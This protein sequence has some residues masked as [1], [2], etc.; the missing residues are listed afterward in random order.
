MISRTVTNAA[1]VSLALTDVG[2]TQTV[3]AAGSM[4]FA[5]L[6]I[7]R[8][9]QPN[10][11]LKVDSQDWERTL[12]RPYHARSGA[13]AESM[14][15]IGD[16]V[17]GGAGFVVRVMPSGA[18]MPVITVTTTLNHG[19]TANTVTTSGIDYSTIPTLVENDILAFYMIDGDNERS[20]AIKVEAADVAAYGA[21]MF[22]VTLTE[23]QDD[24]SVTVLDTQVV[25]L[26]VMAVD[27]NGNSAFIDDVLESNS[28][29]LRSVTDIATTSAFTAVESS[30]FV[31]G[32]SGDN[33]AIVTENY[34]S[35]LD[36]LIAENKDF[37]A[38]IAAGCY[39]DSI[40]SNLKQ[41]AFDKNVSFYYDLEPNLSYEQA[42]SR[43][44]S[45]GIA[46]SFAQCYHLPYTSTDKYYQG[47]AA[48]GLSG[49]IFA[50]K[51]KGVAS[52]TPTGGWHLTPA[53]ETRA[54][55]DRSGLQ[56]NPNAG[57]PDE[58]Q[59]VEKRINKLGHNSAG[60]L[61]VDDALTTRP[62]LDAL[63][64]DNVVSVD[65]AIGRAYIGLARSLKHEPDGVTR[66]GITNGMK[67]I[68]DGFVSSDC[69]V[70]PRDPSEGTE[71]YT[72]TVTQLESDLWQI[73]WS[74][75]VA[76]SAR[77]FTGQPKLLK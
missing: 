75:C 72:L 35:A 56:L 8:K 43:Q 71:P 16:A 41:L 51:A 62:R 34:Q 21:D 12:G 53:G 66:R 22:I 2:N 15:H 68:L 1:Q 65:N 18:Q 6:V 57:K 76:G 61:M 24:A 9:G 14:R 59:M 77:R 23:T 26:N 46:S 33:T 3:P 30:A 60:G 32:T 5:A 74:I 50:A 19:S 25:S 67:A 10:K 44:S 38:V 64:F 27:G 11:V 13:Y 37:Q 48:W 73:V 52:K 20:R 31:G 29:Y 4:K 28:T 42:L 17:K 63:R 49:F 36:T 69:L 45:L 40:V 7:S 47:R 54:T 39:D 58:D 55:I 70:T